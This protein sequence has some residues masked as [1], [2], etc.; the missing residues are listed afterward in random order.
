VLYGGAA[1]G[2]KSH[3]ILWDAIIRCLAMPG[4][5]VLLLRRT[6]PELRDMHIDKLEA[7]VRRFGGTYLKSEN[8]A[9]FENGSILRCGH[10]EDDRALADYLST[11]FDCIYFDELV[12]FTEKQF[13]FIASRAR[14]SKPG[15]TPLVRAATNPGGANAYW[16]KRYFILKDVTLSE[17]PKYD[18]AK[19][20][21]VPATLD[22]NR[23]IDAT[24]EER[25]MSLPSEAMRR[26]YR[27][28]DW[29]IFEGQYFSEWRA[30]TDDG[31]DWHVLS[32][33]P[34]WHDQPLDVAPGLE[35]FRALDWGYTKPGVC[36]WYAPLPDGRLIKFQEYVFREMLAKD[37]AK[38]IRERSRGMRVRY[39]VAD[40]SMWIRDPVAG[41]SVAETFGR[42]KVPVI[43]ADNDRVNGW[44]RLHSH[45]R[46]TASVVT[47]NGVV[48]VP[49]LQ[50]Y[51]AG[52]PYTVRTLPAQVIDEH[53]P[54]DVKSKDTEDHAADET[55]YAVMSRPAPPRTRR[56]LPSRVDTT[57]K[58]SADARR[59]LKASK[60]KKRPGWAM[61]NA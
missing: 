21:F 20:G 40:P 12:T 50:V 53:R 17:D 41:E 61:V 60:R 30:K 15:V 57:F 11:E 55:R 7:L 47:P 13:K 34:T 26:A 46:E 42:N 9:I 48:Q 38:E 29:D 3:A 39:T 37:V 36:G 23:F 51:E 44:H 24:Y 5:R 59:L 49:L 33:L 14:T 28:G 10:V 32:E 6:F 31:R 52:C 58:L 54:E 1:G 35:V 19:Y 25:L 27:Y 45:L 16:V 4:Y 8:R 43:P 2:G 56:E 18:P 22:D